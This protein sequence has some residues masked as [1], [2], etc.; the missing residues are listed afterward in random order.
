MYNCSVSCCEE[1]W[2]VVCNK[3]GVYNCLISCCEKPWIVVCNEVGVYNC[4]ISCCCRE[5]SVE[6]TP[7]EKRCPH[8]LLHAAGCAHSSARPGRFFLR[9]WEKCVQVIQMFSQGFYALF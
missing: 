2:I 3:V 1:S 7:E 4:S 8:D 6:L 9:N 5:P